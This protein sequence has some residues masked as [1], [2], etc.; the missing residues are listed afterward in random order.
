MLFQ[1]KTNTHLQCVLSRMGLDIFRKHLF[2]VGTVGA[3][4]W[5]E[6]VAHDCK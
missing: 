1:L 3:L 2:P 5:P 4:F 6:D